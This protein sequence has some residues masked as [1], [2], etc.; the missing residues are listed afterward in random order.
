MH[1]ESSAAS[2]Y[3]LHEGRREAHLLQLHELPGADAKADEIVR[4]ALHVMCTHPSADDLSGTGYG[5]GGVTLQQFGEKTVALAS[6]GA[7]VMF[8][9]QNDA[10]IQLQKVA[11]HAGIMWCC[12]HR[13]A[14]AGRDMEDHASVKDL[15]RL[16]VNFASDLNGSTLRNQARLQVLRDLLS[17]DIA[18]LSL[19]RVRWLSLFSALENIL[20]QY[21][22][23]T[24]H[25]SSRDDPGGASIAEKLTDTDMLLCMHGIMGILAPINRLC[26][27]LQESGSGLPDVQRVIDD[28]LLKLKLQFID[29]AAEATTATPGSSCGK[30]S[31]DLV[32]ND[33]LGVR[34]N[35]TLD[36]AFTEEEALADQL[37]GCNKGVNCADWMLTDC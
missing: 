13:I 23:L 8:G 29:V 12:S 15:R 31:A 7:R 10:L 6:D 4:E 9:S 22:P 30:H 18:I 26:K 17:K 19:H 21:G 14:L 36:F 35:F 37:Q 20:K 25:Y 16:V 5:E 28:A 27:R 3:L 2:V 33:R 11:P 34:G 24:V 32:S 1:I